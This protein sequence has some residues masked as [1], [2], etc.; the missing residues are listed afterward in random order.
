MAGYQEWFDLFSGADARRL[1]PKQSQVDEAA[2]KKQEELRRITT[3]Q[4]AKGIVTSQDSGDGF[5][6]ASEMEQDFRSLSGPELVAKYGTDVGNQMLNAR[7]AGEADYTFS[8]S[9]PDR[10]P[11]TAIMDTLLGAGSA[12]VGGV[13][14]IAA[15][16]GGEINPELGTGLAKGTRDVTGFINAFRSPEE[17]AQREIVGAQNQYAGRDEEKT[18]QDDLKSGRNPAWAKLRREGRN[19]VRVAENVID[20]PTVLGSVGAEAAG[21]LLSGGAVAKGLRSIGAKVLARTQAAGIATGLGTTGNVVAS[22]GSKAAMPI[23]IGLQEGGGAYAGTMEDAINVLRD[24]D[25]PV[26]TKMELANEAAKMAARLQAPVGAITGLLVSKFE[27]KLASGGLGVNPREALQ[28]AIKETLEESAQSF[29]GQAFQ[30][31]VIAATGIDPNRDLLQG[32]G[33]QVAYGAIGGSLSSGG[34]SLP[35]VAINGTTELA[36]AGATATIQAAKNVAAAPLNALADRG[37]RIREQAQTGFTGESSQTFIERVSSLVPNIPDLKVQEKV[38]AIL[39]DPKASVSEITAKIKEAVA[40][41]PGSEAIIAGMTAGTNVTRQFVADKLYQAL[42]KI[43]AEQKSKVERQLAKV[44]GN[45][46]PEATVDQVMAEVPDLNIEISKNDVTDPTNVPAI[47]TAVAKAVVSPNTADPEINNIILKHSNDGKVSLTPQQK[48]ALEASV[49]LVQSQQEHQAVIASLREKNPRLVSED[50]ELESSQAFRDVLRAVVSGNIDE[51]KKRLD[52]FRQFTQL[53]QNKV[54]ALNKH[55][56]LGTGNQSD[57]VPYM[58]L[59]GDYGKRRWIQSERGMWMNPKAPKTVAFARAVEADARALTTMANNLAKSF[60]ELGFEA[61]PE[62][63]LELNRMPVQPPVKPENVRKTPEIADN[64][65]ADPVQE[66]T[67]VVEAA[68]VVEDTTQ[69]KGGDE[70]VKA[71]VTTSDPKTEAATQTETPVSDTASDK[72]PDPVV[73]KSTPEEPAPVSDNQDETPLLGEKQGVVP[74]FKKAFKSPKE[75]RTRTAG[76]ERPLAAL[77]DAFKSASALAAFIGNELRHDVTPALVNQYK[78]YLAEGDL[79]SKVM[80]KNLSTFLNKELSGKKIGQH[81]LD[82]TSPVSGKGSSYLLNQMVNGKALNIVQVVDGKIRYNPELLEMAVLAGLQ[83]TLNKGQNWAKLTDSTAAAI[84]DLDPSDPNVSALTDELNQGMGLTELNRSMAAEIARYWNVSEN[85]EA[86]IAMVKGISEAVAGEVL[87]ALREQKLI[88]SVTVRDPYGDSK[89]TVDRFFPF[90]PSDELKTFPTAIEEAVM[91]N[92]EVNFIGVAP[93]EVAQSQMNNPRARNTADQ[94]KALKAENNTVYTVNR[95]MADVFE[96]LGK[97]A[98]LYLFGEGDLRNRPLNNN[99]AKTL[100][101]RNLNISMAFDTLISRLAEVRSVAAKNAQWTL[102]TVPIHYEHNFSSIGRMQQLGRNSPQASKLVREVILPTKSTLDL[103]GANDTHSRAYFLSLA[104]SFDMKPENIGVDAAVEKAKAH[105]EKAEIAAAVQI[106]Q[107]W[108][109]QKKKTPFTGEQIGVIRSALG[110]DREVRAFHALLD[111][112]RFQNAEDRSAFETAMYLEADGKTNGPINA[113]GMMTPGAFDRRWVGNMAK[114]GL[115]FDTEGMT[116]AQQYGRDPNDLYKTAANK[117]ST[118]LTALRNNLLE[119]DQVR[120]VG[121]LDAVLYL[122]NAL[123]PDSIVVHQNGDVEVSRGT[124]KNPLTITLYGSSAYGIAGN[125]VTDMVDAI[126]ARMSEAL[127]LM[128]Q[129]KDMSMAMAMFGDQATDDAHAELLFKTFAEKIN[130]LLTSN[131]YKRNEELKIGQTGNDP[132]DFTKLNLKSFAFSKDQISVL[133]QNMNLLVVE[134]LVDAIRSTVG[135]GLINTLEDVRKA[136]QVQGVV[137]QFMFEQEY[138]KQLSKKP[139]GE[140]LSQKEI[141][142]I[143]DKLSYLSPIIDTG[144]AVFDIAGSQRTEVGPAE[145]GRAFDDSS[146]TDAYIYGPKDPGVRGIPTMVI[147]MGD[148]AMMQFMSTMKDAISGTLKVFDGINMPLDKI[149][150]GSRQANEAAL[151]SWL[152]NPVQVVLDSFE[153]FLKDF[154]MPRNEA[155]YEPLTRALFGTAEARLGNKAPEDLMAEIQMIAERLRKT[156]RQIEARH[157]VLKEVNLSVDQMAT[158][159][160]PFVQ[161]DGVD[162]TGM[163]SDQ[164]ARELTG[165]MIEKMKSQEEAPT[166]NVSAELATLSEEHPSGVRVINPQSLPFLAQGLNIPANQKTLLADIISNKMVEGYTV[167]FGTDWQAQAYADQAGIAWPSDEDMDYVEGFA[168]VSNKTIF[169]LS[170][171]PSS[172]TIVHELLHGATFEK[173]WDHYNGRG[174][175]PNAIEQGRAI[176][177][178]EAMLDQFMKL[179]VTTLSEKTRVAFQIAREA[180][181]DAQGNADLTEAGRKAVALNEFM[182]Y[183]LS[184]QDIARTLERTKVENPLARIIRNV[185]RGIS[186][187]IWGNKHAQTAKDDMLSNLRFNTN[188]LLSSGP[189]VQSVIF[190]GVLFQRSGVESENTRLKRLHDTLRNRIVTYLDATLENASERN[191]KY[192]TAVRIGIR[193]AISFHNNGFPMT[194]EEKKTFQMVVAALS[195][196]TIM[197]PNVLVEMNKL[198]QHVTATLKPSNFMVDALSTDPNDLALAQMQYDSVVGNYFS[199]K[200]NDDRSALLSTF[201]ALAMTNETFQRALSQIP[202]PNKTLAKWNTFDGVVENMGIKAMESLSRLMAGGKARPASVDDAVSVLTERMVEIA[203]D[204]DESLFMQGLTLVQKAVNT[205]N[206]AVVGAMKFAG[207]GVVDLSRKGLAS[208]SN[209]VV[210]ALLK[211]TEVIG[212]LVDEKTGAV[213]AQ[214][215]MSQA[216]KAAF[217]PTPVRE[218][219]SEFI[220][221]TDDNAPIYDMIKLVRS[222]VQ[223]TRQQFREKVPTVI[224]NQFTKSLTDEEHKALFRG[225]GK[226]DL[227]ALVMNGFTEA[228]VLELLQDKTALAAEISDIEA[229][230]R[231][232]DSAKFPLWQSKAKELAEYMNTGK[233]TSGNLLRN[234][235]AIGQLRGERRV[236]KLATTDAMVGKIDALTTLYA[237]DSLPESTTTALSSLAQG[238]AKGMTFAFDYL[239]GQRRTEMSKP[240]WT[241]LGRENHYKGYIPTEATSGSSLIIAPVADES[242]LVI[243][244]YQRVG[245][246]KTSSA[247]PRGPSMAYYYSETSRGR[248][249]QGVVQNIRATYSGVDPSSGFTNQGMTGGQITDPTV[250]AAIKANGRANGA[251]GT[252]PLMPIYDGKGEVIAYERSVDP[253]QQVRVERTENLSQ[254]IGVWRGR[255]IEEVQSQEFNGLLIKKLSD[256]WKQQGALRNDEFVNLFDPALLKKDRVLA[257]SVGLLN[258]QTREMIRAQFGKDQFMVRRDM[259]NDVLGYRTPSI[260]DLWTGTTRLSEPMQL[261]VRDALIGVFGV[262]AY[263]NLTKYEGIWQNLITDARVTIVIK[264]MIVPAANLVANMF[265]LMSRGIG[266]GTILKQFP[267]KTAEINLFVQNRV[268]RLELEA[269]LRASNRDPIKTRSLKNQIQAIKDANRRMSIW[270]LIQAG[271]FASISDVGISQDELLLS[272]GR[273]SEYME[274][275][276][277]KLPAS[278]KT[279]GK[280]GIVSRDTALFKGLQRAVEYGDFLGKAVLYDDLTGKGMTPEE[281]LAKIGEEFVNY[282]RLPGRSRTYLENIG[283]LWFW[284]F[285]IRSTKIAISLLRNNP[286]HSLLAMSGQMAHSMGSV[287]SPITD[288]AFA[289]MMDGRSGW[290]IGPRMAIHAHSLNPWYNLTT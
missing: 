176:E 136:T 99:H 275:L 113:M 65:V 236:S 139:D 147:G 278:L 138:T 216:N 35:G 279:M 240:S 283:L 192:L 27:S 256:M 72:A 15:W 159:E 214:D 207:N 250:V 217:L 155:V 2:Q 135:S 201:V 146:K 126:Y 232:D 130:R 228:R 184:N 152:S 251:N 286:L 257:D 63:A 17:K 185:I 80:E 111:Y 11:A 144:K 252:Q 69:P 167:V 253:A 154:D 153:Q 220:G 224:N 20:N 237:L 7:S 200:D 30:N 186:N 233:V 262:N 215:L 64:S 191:S 187:L 31:A 243:L 93:T 86:D 52:D 122:M 205:G 10:S 269:E 274:R 54:E 26:E 33:E 74:W 36:K 1:T 244:G 182:A 204:K 4:V 261:K 105:L 21:S 210:Q 197:D 73:E 47:E 101:G 171:N 222:W 92:P 263:K 169:L 108:L 173:V 183:A 160:A 148:G 141:E 149:E 175:G 77:K 59:I 206:N 211:S 137:L 150:E 67:P 158:A 264:S 223:Q 287:G 60:P 164:I 260:G 188:I 29:S 143:W 289:V 131:A 271:E 97:E 229:S 95:P 102:D 157:E 170:T 48:G 123:N 50:V 37:R 265:Q 213:V 194:R 246:Y 91:I 266:V 129:S 231:A 174:L 42:D 94:K 12:A 277:D 44:L 230:L 89:K 151:Q 225:M 238:E 162:L 168:S 66:V 181:E 258:R 145:F 75:A 268:K 179:D 6:S 242:D 163:T 8:R 116:L 103:S 178:I 125:L 255:Q 203:T 226:T 259:L 209:K 38:S 281:A 51:G 90:V 117:L 133:T 41:V 112:A 165:R 109:N 115:V 235:W 62:I 219:L 18:Y 32:T 239:V 140:N 25:M 119:R 55:M 221:R 61:L 88:G 22:V 272:Q 23:S 280:Y 212:S 19:I 241:E 199:A 68:P 78:A 128:D 85:S 193:A 282:D 87:R 24:K 172:E 70:S 254:S 161:T 34:M 245:L 198:Y 28:G 56:E 234:A 84:F 46:A 83:W 156:A 13:G 45:A 290:S 76:M 100:K 9:A 132:I 40:K 81:L 284:N 118:N 71:E 121:Q 5:N 3:P 82:G 189:S 14:N 247:E 53:L 107:D 127:D 39:A 16:A 180:I 58:N 134:P 190:D 98:L 120:L 276:A 114:G 288:N 166:E 110:E 218:L 49:S 227:A 208:T 142:A 270:P 249:N 96:A 79:I 273:L 248:Y 202:V 43:P 267:K 106:L 285:K 104:Q 196:A 124:A 195:T 177:R 57:A